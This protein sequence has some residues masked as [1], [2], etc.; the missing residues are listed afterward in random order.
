[1]CRCVVVFVVVVL[2]KLFRLVKSNFEAARAR[3]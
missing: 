1:L 3:S 2:R